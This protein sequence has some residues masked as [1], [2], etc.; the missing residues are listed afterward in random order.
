MSQIWKF[1]PQ[2][3]KDNKPK[4]LYV[5][6]EPHNLT[7]LSDALKDDYEVFT[8]ISAAEGWKIIESQD[9]QLVLSDQRMPD[10]QGVEFLE[11]V[12]LTY[13]NVIR[14]LITGFATAETLTEA[15][16]RAQIE[17]T[18]HKPYSQDS[19][20]RVLSRLMESHSLRNEKRLLLEQLKEVNQQLHER[21]SLLEKEAEER[22]EAQ[23]KLA[24]FAEELES[25]VLQRTKELKT[26]NGM[27]RE[28]EFEASLLRELTNATHV[29]TS[30]EDAFMAILQIFILRM[31]WSIGYVYEPIENSSQTALKLKMSWAIKDNLPIRVLRRFQHELAWKAGEGLPGRVFASGQP[32]CVDALSEIADDPRA[33]ICSELNLQGALAFPIVVEEKVVAVMEFLSCD[34]Q[35]FL[36]GQLDMLR[37]VGMQLS[38]VL[39]RQKIEA[40]RQQSLMIAES[41]NQAKSNFLAN[42]SHEIRTPMNSVLGMNRLLQQ[43]DLTPQQEQYVARI[44][45]SSKHLMRLLNDI[46]DSS[47]I[48]AGKLALEQREF[49]LQEVLSNISELLAVN[50]HQQELELVFDI[51]FLPFYLLGDSLRL[52]QV[53]VNLISNAIKFTEVGEVVVRAEVI[54]EYS[55]QVKLKFSVCDSGIG[56]SENQCSKLFQMFAQ[57]DSSISRK[58]GGT[59]LGLSICRS[60]VRLMGGEIWVESIPGEGSNFVFTVVLERGEKQIP[61]LSLPR[62][63][64]GLRVLLIDDNTSS[65]HQT[66]QLLEALSLN[67]TA[68]LSPVN[69]LRSLQESTQAEPYDLYMIDGEMEE[70]QG[71]DVCRWIRNHPILYR[72]PILVLGSCVDSKAL[73]SEHDDLTQKTLLKPVFLETLHQSLLEVFK[74]GSQTSHEKWNECF[75][76]VGWQKEQ[77][78]AEMTLSGID[79]VAGIAQVGGCTET[80]HKLLF[81]LRR[82]YADAIDKIELFLSRGEDDKAKSLLCNLTALACKLGAKPLLSCLQSLED[83]IHQADKEQKE[84]LLENARVLLEGVLGSIAMLEGEEIKA[85]IHNLPQLSPLWELLTNSSSFREQ[86]KLLQL[87]LSNN[88]TRACACMSQILL[89]FEEQHQSKELQQITQ[90]VQGY[91]FDEALLIVSSILDEF[92]LQTE[93]LV[94]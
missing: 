20:K 45:S 43:T 41:A 74:P 42:I 65:L 35:P 47:K 92:E 56:L 55:K 46:L 25:R 90:L 89:N 9:I 86:F 82:Y 33:T 52:E 28:R 93:A 64:Q 63:I 44:H 11:R 49:S 81:K 31:D 21:T 84:S 79:A 8:A 26:L 87:Y 29:A 67:V 58:Y 4:I 62:E 60:L 32:L 68:F 91:D 59:G 54:A 73:Q 5:D 94:C 88:D 23:R 13:P 17:H 80:F 10:V 78:F 85:S 69:G 36:S 75:S 83:A 2:R 14:V 38:V 7:V 37:Q 34:G 30:S 15:I 16:N 48:D 77:S 19:I 39:Q 22:K 53:L 66:K 40:E 3:T 27:L 24:L 71:V 6:D 51:P 12:F 57:V 18:F 1:S 50:A 72:S 76:A 61:P 70:V